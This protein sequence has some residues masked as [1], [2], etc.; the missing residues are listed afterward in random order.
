M[1]KESTKKTEDRTC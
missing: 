1:R